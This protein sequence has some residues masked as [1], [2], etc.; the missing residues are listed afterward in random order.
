MT[1]VGNA[2]PPWSTAVQRSR[3]RPSPTPASWSP[4]TRATSQVCRGA[5]PAHPRRPRRSAARCSTPAP[6]RWRTRSRSPGTLTGRTAVVAFDHALPRPHQPHHGADR[7]DHAVQERLRPVRARGLPRADVLPVP[8]RRPAAGATRPPT[9]AIDDDR[10]AD[11]RE[12]R[13][14]RRS[15]SRSRARA[16]SSCRRR[17]SCRRSPTG[18]PRNGV[19]VHRRRGPDRVL[20]HRRHGSP[21]ST[22]ASCPDLITTAKGIAGGLPLAAVTGRAEIMDAVQSGGLGGTYGG[23][24]VACAAALA[25]I[26]TMRERRTSSAARPADRAHHGRPAASG[27]QPGTR[28]IGDVRGRGAMIA[29]ELVDA[30][31]RRARCR[32][33][34][35]LAT[36]CHAAP[37]VV[38]LTCGTYGNVHPLPAAAGHRRTTC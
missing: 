7:E 17:A 9:G 11:R 23:N 36:A 13:R 30:G 2:A 29:I 37:G 20:P 5:E 32:A 18:A 14:R 27:S 6:R 38:V 16:A 10:E 35:P 33:R 34:R 3:S 24:P 31:H 19:A 1:S 21:A 25:A 12:Q 15:S 28:A 4:R 22:R 8:R 26:E